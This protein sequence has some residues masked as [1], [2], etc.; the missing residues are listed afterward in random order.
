M[1][2]MFKVLAGLA[3]MIALSACGR[4]GDPE[5]PPASAGAKAAQDAGQPPVN[6]RPFILDRLIQ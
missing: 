2:R 3:L 6:D 1:M 5:L 4:A